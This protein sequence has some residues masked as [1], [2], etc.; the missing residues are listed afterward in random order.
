MLIKA[1]NIHVLI[2]VKNKY[3]YGSYE[4]YNL[5]NILHTQ[6]TLLVPVFKSEN[7]GS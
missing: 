5:S 4:L 1:I 2:P 6:V 3:W 7:T